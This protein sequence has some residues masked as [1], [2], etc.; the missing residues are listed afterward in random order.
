MVC[1]THTTWKVRGVGFVF[2]GIAIFLLKRHYAGPLDDMVRAYAGNLSISFALYFVFINL[3]LP[4]RSK[5]L[6]A[7]AITLSVVQLFEIFDGFGIMLNT[8]DPM[9][10][11]VNAAGVALAL[12]LDT[13]TSA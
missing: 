4:M 8:Y 6:L 2:L 3:R 11:G 12:W 1:N 9:D 7:A 10:L 5:R 13:V